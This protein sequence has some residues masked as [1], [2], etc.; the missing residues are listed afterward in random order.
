VGINAFL[1]ITVPELISGEGE[2]G[3]CFVHAASISSITGGQ[4]KIKPDIGFNICR[5]VATNPF[6][7]KGDTCVITGYT[8]NAENP[9]QGG[10]FTLGGF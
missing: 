8:P 4:L 6:S 5:F 3:A 1:E 10:T 7:E 2:L 9:Q